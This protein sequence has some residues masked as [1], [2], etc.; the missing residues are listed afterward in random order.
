MNQNTEKFHKVTMRVEVERTVLA[1][2]PEEA[3][4]KADTSDMIY[5][6]KN[7]SFDEEIFVEEMKDTAPPTE[8]D[9]IDDI[10]EQ[11]V[12]H[13]SEPMYML[14]ERYAEIRNIN[15]KLA[16]AGKQTHEPV[17]FMRMTDQFL[18]R[19]REK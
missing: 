14:K 2:S 6:I 7:H 13:Q 1:R 3:R 10:G 4:E 16:K 19:L 11:I 9:R 15:Q 18:N 17:A 5:E 8:Y 12:Q